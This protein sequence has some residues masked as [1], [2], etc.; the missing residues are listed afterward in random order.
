MLAHS[1]QGLFYCLSVTTIPTHD[2]ST[3][4]H[5]VHF[6][7]PVNRTVQKCCFTTNR[8]PVHFENALFAYGRKKQA[9]NKRNASRKRPLTCFSLPMA[10]ILLMTKYLRS[11]D[12]CSCLRAN[13]TVSGVRVVG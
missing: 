8:I 3:S 12:P 4:L 5:L 1:N 11:E 6:N 9:S 2:D 10:A 7:A 13:S